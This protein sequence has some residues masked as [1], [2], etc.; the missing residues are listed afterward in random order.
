MKRRWNSRLRLFLFFCAAGLLLIVW[1]ASS[2]DAAVRS[3]DIPGV[4][5]C[6]K[7]A[8]FAATPETGL[9]GLLGERPI[10][11]TSDNSPDHIWSTGGFAGLRSHTYDLGCAIDP[12][13]WAR[14]TNASADSA[15]ANTITSIG[16]GLVSLTDSV[17]RRAWEPGWVV[18]FLDDFAARATG[19]VNT[20]ILVPF[21]ALAIT[22]ATIVL[23][24]R[25]QSGDM[26]SAATNV[27][28]VFIVITISSLLLLSPMLA[29]EVSQTAAGTLVATLNDG[30][31]PS[32]AATNQVVKNVQYQGWLRR[33]FGSAVTPVAATYGPDLLASTR[34]SWTELD[35]INALDPKDQ[36][37]AREAL[38]KTKADQFK[39]IAAKVE[40]ED[41]TAYRYLTGQE[42]G[43]TETVVELLTVVAA[44]AIRLAVAILM[45]ACAIVLVM[46]A[47]F[48]LV[49][50]AAILQPRIG[51]RTGQ[52][53]G[54]GLIN[55][56]IQAT[57]YVLIAA[58][59]SWLFG[60]YLQA[61]MAPGVSL[62][63]SLLLLMIGTGIA[64]AAIGPIAKFKAIVSFGR[65]DG[66]SI[67]GRLL[68]TALISYVGGSFAGAAVAKAVEDKV[69]EPERLS[70]DVTTPTVVQAN[71]YHPTPAFVPETPTTVDAEPLTGHIVN[72]LPA[73]YEVHVDA[74]DIPP[75]DDASSPYTPYERSDDNEGARP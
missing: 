7:Q 65:A 10:V 4:E 30:A 28:W 20:S 52:E 3:V 67:I 24:Y 13:S 14:I 64:W 15:I 34:V 60:V 26:S 39:D 8:P 57:V 32:D 62:W 5:V 59:G 9:A 70:E 1:A 38:T 56:A 68:K 29:S 25:A 51:R 11:V 23:L 54:M 42:S 61:C 41:P 43:S 27:G 37:K 40:A 2:S 49:L 50:T 18:A 22:F 72:A 19:V 71:I 35:S 63:W 16:D 36:P 48:W 74:S 66:H 46:L 6:P 12:T 17:D 53:L 21:L 45:I 31:N 75:P 55:N 33:N 73:A 58:V 44:C 47:I 69:Q